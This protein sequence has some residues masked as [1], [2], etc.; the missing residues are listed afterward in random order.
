MK[1]TIISLLLTLSLVANVFLV[2]FFVFRGEVIEKENHRTAIVMTEGNRE[3]VL[4]EMRSFLSN[5][6]QINEGVLENNPD[7]IIKAA[8][9]SGAGVA[10]TV[11]QGLM[12][13][14][15]IAFKKMGFGTH[16]LFDELADS[17]RTNYSAETTQKQLNQI[18][19]RCV[20][21]HQVYEIQIKK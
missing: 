14:L 10:E 7:K 20:T 5:L 18:M 1:K 21:C 13:S 2:Y 3:I 8:K 9:A 4:G 17:A 15:P 11:P 6:Q 12:K 19:Q 16:D